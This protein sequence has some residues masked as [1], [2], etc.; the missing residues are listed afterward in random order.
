MEQRPES[1]PADARDPDEVQPGAS[2]RLPDLARRGRGAISNRP[3]RF[4][5]GDRPREDDGWSDPSDDED[6]PPLKTT[7]TIDAT[8]SAIAWNESPDLGFDRSVNPYRGCEHGCVYCFARPTHAWLGLS[9]GLDFETKLFAKP[10][11]PRLLA[12]ELAKPGYKPALMA[13]GTNTDPYQ[14]I[15]RTM[16]ITRGVLETLAAFNH[17]VGIVTK[18]TLV[19]RD[20]DILAP[21]ARL[22]LASVT[23]SVTTLDRDLARNLEPRAATPTRRLETIRRLAE[24]GIPVGVLAAPMIPA[25]NDAEME[26]IFQAAVEAGASA[27][28][29]VLL[30]LPMEIKDLFAEWLATHA[31][32]KMKHVLN[33]IR[34]TRRGN[35]YVDEFGERMRGHGPYAELLQRRYRLALKRFG[36]AHRRVIHRTDLFEVPPRKGQQMALF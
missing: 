32:A 9:P 1:Q 27:A 17:P 30:R 13:L 19:L 36:L 33:L 2:N 3:G 7:V 29:Y 35:L 26:A 14:P 15:E 28:G 6:L 22:G 23:L 20:I 4:E 24:A 12:E 34:D 10:E 16:K 5:K 31:P 8:R 18:S 25:L 11:A 21:M